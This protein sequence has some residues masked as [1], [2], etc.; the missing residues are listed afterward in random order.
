MKTETELAGSLQPTGNKEDWVHTS[1]REKGEAHRDNREDAGGLLLQDQ[2]LR[3]LSGGGGEKEFIEFERGG[4]QL[5]L[6]PG[7]NWRERGE[8][9]RL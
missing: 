2:S 1:S 5:R 6:K 3:G 8:D 9:S 7:E 4:K